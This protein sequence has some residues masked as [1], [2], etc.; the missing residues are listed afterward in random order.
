M[1]TGKKTFSLFRI[2]CEVV[3][4]QN[5]VVVWLFETTARPQWA[6]KT[7]DGCGPVR[8]HGKKDGKEIKK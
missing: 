8:R 7:V 5:I 3:L 1:S 4:S 2:G 6:V